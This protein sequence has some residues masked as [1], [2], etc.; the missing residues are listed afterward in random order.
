MTTVIRAAGAADFLAL[1]PRLLGFVPEHSLVLIPFARGRTL[2]A[3][4][5]DLPDAAGAAELD[6][7]ASTSVGL[8]CK[9]SHTDAVAAVVFTDREIGPD[10]AMPYDALIRA[11]LLRA[12]LCGLGVPEALCLSPGGWGSYLAPRVPAG[13]R[14][15]AEIPFDHEALAD[16]PCA[17]GDQS[18][19]A[20]LP[21][22]DLAEK[23]RVARALRH[24]TASPG[25]GAAGV[26]DPP[27]LFEEALSWP[28]DDLLPAQAATMV[29]ALDRP[30][31]RDIAL[32]QWAI[33]RARGE[34]ALTAQRAW[35]NGVPYPADIAATMWGEGPRP[36]A[37]RLRRA[38]A[39]A[40]RLAAVAPRA[41]RP[42]P[43][44]ACAWLSWALGNSTHAGHHA[45][46]A[47]EIDPSH[48]LA[49][50]VLTLVAGAHLPEWT[51][52][53]RARTDVPAT[54]VVDSTRRAS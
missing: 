39:L 2:G 46:A 24:L 51:F 32:V 42:G 27:A 21:S 10:G 31:L 52:E 9:V 50:I 48:G 19:G 3:M 33:G 30:A 18:S 53:H 38:L 25:R 35:E 20:Q 29:Y 47:R 43:L 13:G 23:E 15:R 16:L 41:S 17:P 34:Q 36:D 12:D 37:E 6:A 1:V 4:R 28:A 5:L 45:T 7:F 11:V 22:A 44:A 8:T 40:R 26:G 54:R 49:G 14:P